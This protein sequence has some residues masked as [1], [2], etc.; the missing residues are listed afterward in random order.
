MRKEY[1]IIEIIES[2]EAGD[3][4]C[5]YKIEARSKF[6]FNLIK[7]NWSEYKYPYIDGMGVVQIHYD[8]G[9][10][11]K[12]GFVIDDYKTADDILRCLRTYTDELI[13]PAIRKVG[14]SKL[15]FRC[16]YPE[17]SKYGKF[18][19]NL[20]E[21]IDWVNKNHYSITRVTVLK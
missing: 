5:Y 9:T 12:F 17:K 3:K 1:R 16:K 21:A 11:I 10:C 2:N 7:F 19:G 14:D 18:F 13:F 4:R 20:K 8:T 15:V 6:L